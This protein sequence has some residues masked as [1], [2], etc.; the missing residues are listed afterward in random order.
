MGGTG[1]SPDDLDL[2][3]Y[4]RR[5]GHDRP[6]EASLEVLASLQSAHVASI[7]FENVDVRLGRPIR[8]DLPSLHRKLVASRRGGYCFEHN[9]LFCAALRALGFEVATLEARV[10]PPGAAAVLGRT[11]MTL[12][13]DVG[14]RSFLV[15][16]GFGAEGPQRPVPLDGGVSVEALGRYRVV[17]EGRLQ[18]LQLARGGIWSDLYAFGPEPAL[19]IDYEVANHYTSTH[20][21]SGFVRTLTL[22]VSRPSERLRLRGLTFTSWTAASGEETREETAAALPGLV[23]E[24]FGLDVPDGD[25]LSALGDGAAEARRP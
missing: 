21:A 14:G 11:H 6:R 5:T 18:V 12:R 19:P 1:S 9:T 25:L 15:D 24:R 23:R 22:A 3:A 8:L 16:S 2:D 10:R 20:P 7:P 17:P 4:L 13:V